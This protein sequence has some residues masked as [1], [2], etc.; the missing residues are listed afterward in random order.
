M[1]CDA[2][3]EPIVPVMKPNPCSWKTGIASMTIC[4]SSTNRMSIVVPAA[5]SSEDEQHEPLDVAVAAGSAT[6]RRRRGR[7]RRRRL[8]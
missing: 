8:E 7:W 2:G 3:S 6:R 5:T 4:A 1:P